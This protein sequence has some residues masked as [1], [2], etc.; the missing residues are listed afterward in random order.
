MCRYTTVDTHHG[1]T[2]KIA[3]TGKTSF[4][5]AIM[6]ALFVQT[7][8]EIDPKLANTI[9]ILPWHSG[10][11]FKALSCLLI[12]LYVMAEVASVRKHH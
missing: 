1:T 10:E 6:P 11:K 4:C 3:N 8:A 9:T 7:L 2:C 12:L 5:R